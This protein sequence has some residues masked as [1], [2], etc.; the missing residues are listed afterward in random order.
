ANTIVWSREGVIYRITPRRNN[1]VND[2]WMADTGRLLYKQVKAADRLAEIHINGRAS[3]RDEAFA[4][5]GQIF[6]SAAGAIA[7]VGSGRSTVE[8][9]FVTKKLSAA[10]SATTH[11]VSHVSGGDGLLVSADRTP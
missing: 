7:I 6:K 9:Q 5:A 1:E 4:A 11:L 10:L 3:T 2:E 8:E